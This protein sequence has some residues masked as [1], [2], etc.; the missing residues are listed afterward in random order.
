MKDQDK[1]IKEVSSQL[2][3]ESDYSKEDSSQLQN[4][5]KNGADHM[6]SLL[7]SPEEIKEMFNRKTVLTSFFDEKGYQ[8]TFDQWFE[9]NKK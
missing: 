2:Y 4:A 9:Q 1:K 5:F 6:K 3:K 7:Y 8:I